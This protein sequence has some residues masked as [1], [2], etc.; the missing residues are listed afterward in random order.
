MKR[1]RKSNGRKSKSLNWSAVKA[2][3]HQLDEKEQM[4]LIKDLYNISKENRDFLHT[5]FSIGFNP[6]A[7]YKKV[8]EDSLYPD[9]M[10]NEDFQYQRAHRAIK[11]YIAAGGSDEGIIDLMIYFVECGH[12]FTLDYGDVDEIF[13]DTLIEM[14]G[15]AVNK[16]LTLPKAKQK[17][18]LGRLKK[19]MESSDGIGWGYHDDICHYYY[20]VLQE[21]D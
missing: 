4:F 21:N 20:D 5:R 6:E 12:Q 14:Y 19:I 10:G 3:I 17:L 2:A 8:I 11:N 9:V 16:I 7:S 13:Y 1:E 15:K 18:F